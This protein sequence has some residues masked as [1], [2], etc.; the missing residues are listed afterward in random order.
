MS[1]TPTVLAID[2]T[3]ARLQLALLHGDLADTS[4]DEIGKG[5]AELLFARLDALLK[6]N[7]LS[8]GDLT[9]IAVTS[10][11]GSFTGLRVGLAA[12]RGLGL[13][14]D[15]PVLGIPTLT[16]LSLAGQGAFAV[17]VDARR[18]EAYCQLFTGAG[19][20]AAPAE[21]VPFDAPPVPSGLPI[22][23]GN[24]VDI[25]LLATFAA[26][27]DPAVYPPDAFYLRSADAKPQNKARIA[28]VRG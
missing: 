12:A 19:M 18:S 28:R 24:P 11:P 21:V 13:T 1:V 26:N 25:G 4:I 3:G 23:S 22:V 17:I 6:R 8:Y 16:A 20:P 10:G 5:H 14:L 15:I 9:C 2:T 7:G 27:A